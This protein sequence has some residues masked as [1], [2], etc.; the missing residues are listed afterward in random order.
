[1]HRVTLYPYYISISSED[2]SCLMD[3]IVEAGIPIN[4][5]CGGKGE[6]GK[7]KVYV[8]ESIPE[9]T[10]QSLLKGDYSNLEFQLTCQTTVDS[11]IEVFIPPASVT[12]KM[13]VLTMC[14]D[15]DLGKIDPLLVKYHLELPPPTLD[16]NISDIERIKRELRNQNIKLSHVSLDRIQYLGKT[17]RDA[18][19]DITLSL[20]LRDSGYE[21]TEIESGDTT[22]E[23]LGLAVDL[24]TTTIAANLLDLNTGEVVSSAADYNKQM[25]HGEDVL[26]RIDFSGD[27]KGLRTM[28]GLAVK[29]INSLIG[30]LGKDPDKIRAMV[31]AGNTVMTHLLYGIYPRFIKLEPYIPVLNTMPLIYA[32]ELGIRINNRAILHSLPSRAGYVGGDIT[33][34]ILATR[35]YEKSEISIMIDVGTNG[36][37]VVGNKDWLV[38][39]A[40]SAGPAFEGGEV[41]S[42]MRATTGAIEQI[43]INPGSGPD[44]KTIGNVA[45]VGICG[46]GLIDLLAE[47]FTHNLIDR[48][49]NLQQEVDP[50]RIRKGNEGAEYVVV[51]KSATGNSTDIVITEIDIQSII[52]SKAAVYA[53]TALLLRTVNMDFDDMDKIYIAGGFG[54]Y[55]DLRKAILLGLLPDMSVDKFVFIGNGSLTGAK[56]VLL[57]RDMKEQAAD[58]NK[59][60]TYVELSVNK[61]FFDE[62]SSASFI[63]HT[64]LEQFPSVKKIIT[65]LKENCNTVINV[66]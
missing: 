24:G 45:P 58:I 48:K 62:F 49:G 8:K 30:K 65:V 2:G 25:I 9:S 16:D 5:V 51:E 35:M 60:L 29:T 11:N 54:N 21:L 46:S 44:Y 39:C 26:T 19:W 15:T 47:L 36:E 42:G 20:S 63:P 64:D 41:E 61:D 4:A 32:K 34:D 66:P 52:R 57:S 27:A 3:A 17:L 14:E 10:L 59:K 53:A 40:C 28:Q 33:A 37:V 12:E 56:T 50:R 13:K 22:V 31:I 43:D 1:M 6:C 38:G 55:I 18:N 7:C 23:N